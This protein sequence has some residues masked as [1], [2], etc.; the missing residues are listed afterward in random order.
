M[1]ISV[2][3]RCFLELLCVFVI[4]G[5][6]GSL[7]NDPVVSAKSFYVIVTTKEC[8]FAFQAAALRP[9]A[10]ITGKFAK[11][12]QQMTKCKQGRMPGATTAE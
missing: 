10:V 2:C 9:S 5:V 4:L 12:V 11:L 3:S 7:V 6:T 8:A 1:E